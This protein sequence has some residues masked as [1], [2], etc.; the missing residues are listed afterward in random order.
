MHECVHTCVSV[1]V[2]VRA[3]PPTQTNPEVKLSQPSTKE[4]SG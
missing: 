2:C 4:V 1:S 3:L